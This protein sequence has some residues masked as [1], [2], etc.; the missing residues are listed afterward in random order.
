[1]FISFFVIFSDKCKGGFHVQ[2]FAAINQFR[3]VATVNS[4]CDAENSSV[5]WRPHTVNH[6]ATGIKTHPLKFLISTW[7]VCD[8]VNDGVK[9][10]KTTTGKDLCFNNHL[11]HHPVYLWDFSS[12]SPFFSENNEQINVT[13]SYK[14]MLMLLMLLFNRH[15][16]LRGSKLQ[17]F[18]ILVH[19]RISTG[20]NELLSSSNKLNLFVRFDIF[21][22]FK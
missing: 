13:R 6:R 20:T 10:S 17:L 1:M 14:E 3:F 9:T 5:F 2:M 22:Y 11:I 8:V 19:F 18:N 21:A 16:S 7:P 4:L 15:W 12:I